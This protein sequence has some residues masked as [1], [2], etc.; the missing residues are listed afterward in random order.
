MQTPPFTKLANYIRGPLKRDILLSQAVAQ[1]VGDT[2]CL[3]RA[4]KPA[5]TH[6]QKKERQK[7]RKKMETAY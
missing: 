2:K 4:P 6:P 1:L 7:E 3:L 5:H